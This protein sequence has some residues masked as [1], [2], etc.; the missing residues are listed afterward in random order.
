MNLRAN[1]I[2]NNRSIAWFT[3]EN[4]PRSLT[5]E[6]GFEPDFDAPIDVSKSRSSMYGGEIQKYR[7]ASSNRRIQYLFVTGPR[8]VWIVHP[9]PFTVELSSY[10]LRTVDAVADEDLFIP[11]YEFSDHTGTGE[12]DDQIPP[13]FA[14]D[15]CPADPDRAD[16]SP[17]NERM[18]VIQSFRR[19]F[20]IDRQ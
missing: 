8:H 11:G 9:Q 12:M 19:K 10:G 16:A 15:I 7:I 13:G 4:D 6:P 1:R 2:N 14:G 3:D 20:G 18:P 17:W 5:F